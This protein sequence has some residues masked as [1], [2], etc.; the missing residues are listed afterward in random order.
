[1]SEGRIAYLNARLLDPASGLDAT[2]AVLVEDGKIADFGPGLFKGGAPSV[3]RVIDCQ[4][5]CL[6][7]GFI[8][9]R[10]LVPEP[11]EEHKETFDSAS[12]A[13]LAG[14]ITAY[15]C[16]PNT[17]PAIDNVAGVQYVARRAR[18]LKRAKAYCYGAI[19]KGLEGKELTELGLLHEAGALAFTDGDKA[20][21]N[22]KV[23]HRALS[24]SKA[25]DLLVVQ[26]PAEPD[27]VGS[28]VM[29]KGELSSRLGLG[30]IPP[31]AE[32]MMIERDLRLV[33]MTGAR[34]HVAHVSTKMAVDVIREAKRKGLKVTCDTA[35]HY[36]ALN[37]TSVG[38]YRTFAKVSPPLRDEFD[39]RAIVEGLADGTI[40]LIASDH[41]PHDQDSK[42]L[43]FAL[44]EFGIIGMET[45][46]AL[47]LE[48]YH[49]GHLS[50]LD[51]IAKITQKP[52]H[53][54]RMGGGRLKRGEAAD[55]T[56]FDPD[57]PGTIREDG[58]RSKSN[59]SPYDGRPIQG[60]VMA[61][62][63][64]GRMLFKDE[65]F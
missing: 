3:S 14:G 28:G 38:D 57:R 44:A 52:A 41:I 24:Y 15:V 50:L 2:G 62:I 9:M 65:G 37:E 60:R 34:Y 59:N 5:N 16:L 54:L 10:V 25:F 63:V 27:L 7:P 20:V 31:E 26:H 11:G 45:L 17:E 18:D 58:F 33:E 39:R 61:T 35:P 56:I 46:L 43:P 64:D 21:A 12:E 55:L 6:S 42:R 51:A 53:V 49:N 13:A 4:G 29:N 32:V 8:D 23:M 40:D 1:M 36:F 48:L 22:A 19:T 30:G 47:T